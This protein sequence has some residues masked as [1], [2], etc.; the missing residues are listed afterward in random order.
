MCARYAGGAWSFEPHESV[1]AQSNNLDQDRLWK[2]IIPA[3]ERM[4]VL[5]H[6]DKFNLNDF[7]LFDSEESLLEMLERLPLDMGHYSYLACRK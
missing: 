7:T 5:S 1:F 4:K 3:N 6:L 2:I